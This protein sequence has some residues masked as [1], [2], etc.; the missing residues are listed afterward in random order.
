MDVN[1]GNPKNMGTF[2]VANPL[3]EV[4]QLN[5]PTRLLCGPGP[6]NAHPRVHAAMSLPMI[7]HMDEAFV[8]GVMGDIEK[9][10]NYAWQ[11]SNSFTLPISGTGSAAWEAAVA[12]LTVPGDVHLVFV[13]GYFGERHCDMASRYGAVIKRV[14]K[15]WGDVFSFDEITEAVHVNKPAIVWMCLAETSTGAMQPMDGIGSLCRS[16]GCLLVLDTVTA[17]GGIPVYLDAW[18]VDC[19]YAGGQKCLSCPPGI[20]PLTMGPRAIEKMDARQ[21][22]V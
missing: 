15:K 3:A 9:L 21:K 20:A 7:G 12:N 4:G 11:T 18:Q 6:S 10:L 2:D 5:P 1:G 19:S 8:G 17:I 14:E 22:V 13:N 16:V